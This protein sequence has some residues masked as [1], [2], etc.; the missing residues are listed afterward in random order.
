MFRQNLRAGVSGLD[1]YITPMSLDSHERLRWIGGNMEYDGDG[2][3]KENF[4]SDESKVSL[5]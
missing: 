5:K 1:A 2:F 3:K 4:A